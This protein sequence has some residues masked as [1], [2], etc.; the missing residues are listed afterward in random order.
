MSK[1][2]C[3]LLGQQLILEVNKYKN[4]DV[5]ICSYFSCFLPTE[6][7]PGTCAITTLVFKKQKPPPPRCKIE[8]SYTCIH[9]IKLV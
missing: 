2:F 7:V 6:F 8:K 3:F 1:H 4:R 5:K 9:I